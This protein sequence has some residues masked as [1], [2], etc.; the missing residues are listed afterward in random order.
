MPTD[1][2]LD[3]VKYDA[4][5]LITAIAQDHRTGEVLM[6]AYM[7]E[8]TLRQTLESGIM[9]YWSRSRR[10][11]WVKGET[12]GNTQEVQEVRIDCDGD[13]LLFKVRQNGEAACH[14]GFRSCFHRRY[15]NGRLQ[16]DGDRVFDPDEVYG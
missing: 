14:T 12:S 11:V 10:K 7:N 13:A 5:G 6:L 2:L 15:E 3:H 4:N 8:T 16:I 9:A 1:E